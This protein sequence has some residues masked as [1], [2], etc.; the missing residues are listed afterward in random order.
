MFPIFIEDFEYLGEDVNA[1][2]V[3]PFVFCKPGIKETTRNHERIHYQQNIETLFVGLLV[4]YTYDYIKGLLCGKNSYDS[5]MSTRS[6]IEAYDNE[7]NLKYL[8]QRKR[9]QWI[10]PN[11]NTSKTTRK[12]KKK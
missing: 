2:T 6:E 7:N 11:K 9:Y 3:G 8:S 12:L 5:Y 10:F 4:I 1:M